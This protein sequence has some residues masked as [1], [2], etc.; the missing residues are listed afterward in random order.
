MLYCLSLLLLLPPKTGSQAVY[1]SPF[2]TPFVNP[3]LIDVFVANVGLK[4]TAGSHHNT[5]SVSAVSRE[6]SGL[7]YISNNRS[8]CLL[9]SS[10][11]CIPESSEKQF[12]RRPISRS[13]FTLDSRKLVRARTRGCSVKCSALFFTFLNFLLMLS[14]L[15][16]CGTKYRTSS[17]SSDH[18]TLFLRADLLRRSLIFSSSQLYSEPCAKLVNSQLVDLRRGIILKNSRIYFSMVL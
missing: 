16:L 13:R 6:I 7:E 1:N 4:N 5:L 2:V 10:K 11:F 12:V 8:H 17:R 14:L 9:Y 3:R 15:L 18:C